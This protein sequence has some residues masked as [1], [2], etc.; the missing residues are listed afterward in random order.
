MKLLLRIL[1][2]IIS[3]NWLNIN[4]NSADFDQTA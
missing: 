1:I 3:I 4:P 2:T